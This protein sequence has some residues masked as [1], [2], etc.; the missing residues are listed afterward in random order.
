MKN[1]KAHRH[2]NA[3]RPGQGAAAIDDLGRRFLGFFQDVPGPRKEAVAVLRQRQFAGSAL[4][5]ASAERPFQLGQALAD[6]RLGKTKPPRTFA[7]RSSIGCRQE[8]RNP[9]QLHHCS[10]FPKTNFGHWRLVET[11]HCAHSSVERVSECR[12]TG[13]LPCFVSCFS[14][15][16]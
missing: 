2:G 3:K 13:N 9:I 4:K 16:D 6:N 1:T 11:M 14:S 12:T 7:D 5:E 8:R 15:S 10:A